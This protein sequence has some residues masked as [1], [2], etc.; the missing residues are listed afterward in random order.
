M[1]LPIDYLVLLLYLTY[2]KMEI[3]SVY[4]ICNCCVPEA[5]GKRRPRSQVYKT[6][7]KMVT[8]HRMLRK[9]VIWIWGTREIPKRRYGGTV[10]NSEDENHFLSPSYPA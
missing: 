4:R 2:K 7:E 5:E 8:E 3:W 9:H 10:Q 6:L 1:L